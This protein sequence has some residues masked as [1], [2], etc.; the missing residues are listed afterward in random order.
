MRRDLDRPGQ[1]VDRR[2]LRCTT[3]DYTAGCAGI[4]RGTQRT[5]PQFHKRFAT[6]ADIHPS[7]NP[8]GASFDAAVLKLNQAVPAGIK[9]IKLNTPDQAG[10]ALETPGR[11][12]TAAGWG[13]TSVGGSGA[14]RMNEA[15][16]RVIPD[17]SAQQAWSNQQ[18]V[19]SL[20]VATDSQVG[21]D[22]GTGDSGGPLFNPG[23]TP[24]QVGIVSGNASGTGPG[25]KPTAYTDVNNP[26]IRPFIVY[27]AKQ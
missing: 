11:V 4:R 25:S 2:P 9:P 3:T 5:L 7:Y 20:M 6:R 1:R 19:P 17:A 14:D 13:L 15:S 10:I 16:L 27:T 26:E 8:N 24:T 18:Y 23:A 22:I 21:K 12:L